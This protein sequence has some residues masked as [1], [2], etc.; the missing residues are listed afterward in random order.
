MSCRQRSSRALRSVRAQQEWLNK[1]TYPELAE[2]TASVLFYTHKCTNADTCARPVTLSSVRRTTHL[3]EHQEL[4]DNVPSQSIPLSAEGKRDQ[5]HTMP[6]ADNRGGCFVISVP[7]FVSLRLSTFNHY[8]QQQR[9]REI[10]HS[11]L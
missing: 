7:V 11:V 2:R 8:Q 6:K 3:K 9:P 5:T 10:K 4:S 1:G